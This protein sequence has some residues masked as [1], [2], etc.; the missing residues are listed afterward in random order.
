MKKFV[1]LI[2]GFLYTFSAAQAKKDSVA[3]FN[4]KLK[5]SVAP[6]VV[7]GALIAAGSILSDQEKNRHITQTKVPFLGYFEDYAQFAPTAASA[8]FN[9][10]GMQPRTDRVN[11]LAIAAKTTIINFGITTGLKYVIKKTR[12]DGS[13]RRSFP[14]THTAT[15]FAGATSLST[16]YGTNYPWV[17][18]A[19]YSVA[20]GVGALRV[21]ITNIT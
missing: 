21:I 12:P 13:N 10:G 1:I 2:L 8:A 11:S 15:A 9:F 17:P 7:S 6:V 5:F 18:Y 19:A 16:E 14:S 20:A 4:E 3:T